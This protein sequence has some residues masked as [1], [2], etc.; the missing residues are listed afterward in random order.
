M[1]GEQVVVVSQ[2]FTTSIQ[3]EST[4]RSYKQ[5]TQCIRHSLTELILS[6]GW[7]FWV[8]KY[9]VPPSSHLVERDLNIAISFV[10][11]CC[12]VVIRIIPTHIRLSLLGNFDGPLQMSWPIV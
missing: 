2:S 10:E 12:T 7:I 8:P 9:I 1:L 6:Q 5:L 4:V 3:G 11:V